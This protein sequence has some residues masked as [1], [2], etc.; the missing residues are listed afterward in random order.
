MAS[1]G[2]ACQI[3]RKVQTLVTIKMDT[4][5]C[6]N[7]KLCPWKAELFVDRCLYDEECCYGLGYR[8]FLLDESKPGTELYLR[9]IATDPAHLHAAAPYVTFT[10]IA[11]GEPC[12][13]TV[14]TDES[15]NGLSCNSI[16][17]IN[18]K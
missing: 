13:I 18:N 6:D 17:V 12:H 1:M 5:T 8:S 9:V 4:F 10:L 2:C 14:I 15:V 11:V 16:N 3:Q 7:Q